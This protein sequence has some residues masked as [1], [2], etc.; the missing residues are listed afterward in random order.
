MSDVWA[1]RLQKVHWESMRA[2][3][4]SGLP[5][6]ACGIL[7]GTKE[8]VSGVFPVTN[9]L[10]SPVRFRMDPVEQLNTMARIEELEQEMIG[11][12][13]SHVQGPSVPSNTDL[14]QAY[15]PELVYLIWF[16]I[17]DD[18]DCRAFRLIE[19]TSI[20]IPIHISSE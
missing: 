4:L 5:N 1:I 13:H 2:H 6:E 14:E 19:G 9:E 10:N 3:I 16:P 11:I 7:A 17:D 12:F 20:E 15:Y 8:N 18:W